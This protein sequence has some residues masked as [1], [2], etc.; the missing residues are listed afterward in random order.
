[1]RVD[2]WGRPLASPAHPEL[3]RTAEESENGTDL[4]QLRDNLRLTAGQRLAKAA[5][6][7]R[8]LA[9]LRGLAWPPGTP[10]PERWPGTG[11][12]RQ[13]LKTPFPE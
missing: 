9:R 7:S 11:N 4:V 1:M 13:P 10:R 3:Y 6:A 8:S 12:E 2:P 5:A